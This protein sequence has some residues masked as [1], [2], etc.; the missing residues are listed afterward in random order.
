MLRF[1]L[2]YRNIVYILF[3]TFVVWSFQLPG[4]KLPGIGTLFPLR[5]VVFVVGPF[6]LIVKKKS[7]FIQ[8]VT[9]L[10]TLLLLVGF[11]SLLWCLDIR[12]GLTTFIIYL[13]SI[14]T[15]FTILCFVRN[16]DDIVKFCKV[17]AFNYLVIGLM[18][19]YESMTGNSFWVSDITYENYWKV[20]V[21]G[22]KYPHAIFYNM[23]DFACFMV[24][25]LPL[26]A[27]ALHESKVKYIIQYVSIA[28]S[29]FIALLCNSRLCLLMGLIYLF[30]N[31][32]R[33]GKN[34]FLVTLC[35]IAAMLIII[36]KYGHLFAANFQ[37]MTN[38]S[39]GNESRVDIWANS[40]RN[41]VHSFGLG[42]G[43]GNSAEANRVNSYY[44]TNGV[45]AVHNYFIEILEEF[46]VAGFTCFFSCFYMIFK[47]IWKLRKV[48]EVGKNLCDAMI[49]YV[50]LTILSSSI[51][52]AY[53]FWMVWALCLVFIR[54]HYAEL[55]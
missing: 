16:D 25:M 22:W 54:Y 8:R 55:R 10:L 53:Y 24:A 15:I 13:T 14:F 35:V 30:W 11:F 51:R 7:P 29:V 39:W 50:P 9:I 18:G 2:D 40:L 19:L 27:L 47:R 6:F 49:M 32:P 36:F 44:Y 12:T 41:F 1:K 48:N 31:L 17:I 33:K 5:M 52:Q 37:A 34:V 28:F 38:I 20:N 3:A 4:I 26:I 43:I 42:V 46:G 21:L 45:Y 23:N